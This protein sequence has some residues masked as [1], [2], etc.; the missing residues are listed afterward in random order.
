MINKP[1][2]VVILKMRNSL[3]TMTK[4]LTFEKY[5]LSGVLLEEQA[6]VVFLCSKLP[7]DCNTLQR[8]ATRC[9]TLQHTAT[10]TC[11]AS[12]KRIKVPVKFL[13]RKLPIDC[14]T[15]QHTATHCNTLQHTATHCNTLQHTAT[16]TCRASCQR[17]KVPVKFSCGKLPFD[18]SA[19]SH[20]LLVNTYTHTHTQTQKQ[21]QRH[22]HTH[23]IIPAHSP[24]HCM[25]THV[26]ND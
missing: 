7:I 14:N 22:T 10:H 8:T 26:F 20:T 18:C 4:E 19:Q 15:L 3:C 21:R 9:N 5:N 16:H 2:I 23:S 17:I 24:I 13:C 1:P 11:R 12:C 6:P 25:H